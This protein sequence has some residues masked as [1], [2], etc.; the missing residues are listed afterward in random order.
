MREV[1]ARALYDLRVK[2]EAENREEFRKAY[3]KNVGVGVT[4]WENARGDHLEQADVVIEAI[5]SNIGWPEIRA[6]QAELDKGQGVHEDGGGYFARAL[7][8]LFGRQADPVENYQQAA[9]RLLRDG[10]N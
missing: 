2:R 3:G 8:A 5:H 9:E 4:D 1:I 6:Y 7:G 10:S